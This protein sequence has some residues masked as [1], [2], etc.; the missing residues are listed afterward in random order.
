MKTRAPG[1][2][3]VT[4]LLLGASSCAST[5]TLRVVPSVQDVE[6]KDGETLEARVVI[7]WRGL[8]EVERDGETAHEVN[9]RLRIENPRDL[10][11]AV[12]AAELSLL[13]GALTPFAPARIA[14]LPAAVEPGQEATFDVAFPT[15]P[16]K[17]LDDLDLSAL[18]LG[19]SF[20]SGRWHFSQT[21]QRA[22]YDP[23][24]DPY[25]G[26]TWGWHVGIGIG[27]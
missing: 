6:L 26:P 24:Y 12:G 21:F 25:W 17:E 7:A 16:G 11:F 9:L 19:V 15:P 4:L 10:P 1:L 27:W 8:S 5:P 20:Q 2:A 13:D 23:Y 22:R 3:S 14:G 18:H